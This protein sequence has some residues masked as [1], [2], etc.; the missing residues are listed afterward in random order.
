MVNF[1]GTD[2]IAGLIMLRDYYCAPIC[3]FSIPASEHSTITTWGK[4]GERDAFANM[5]E[6][7]PTGLVACVSDSYDIW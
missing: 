3:G 5:L 7:F 4:D 1:N 6:Q 2:T